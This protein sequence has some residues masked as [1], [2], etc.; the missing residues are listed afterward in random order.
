MLEITHSHSLIRGTPPGCGYLIPTSLFLSEEMGAAK[1]VW[2]R[3][4]GQIEA[5]LP[6]KLVPFWKAPAGEYFLLILRYFT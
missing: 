1:V 2:G 3:F 6:R 4:L 5:V